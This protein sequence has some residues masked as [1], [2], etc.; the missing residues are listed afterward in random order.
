[1]M[2]MMII[3][4]IISVGLHGRSAISA[5]LRL[6]LKF[7]CKIIQQDIP[8]G[9]YKPDLPC[10]WQLLSC[11]AKTFGAECLLCNSLRAK[12]KLL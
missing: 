2:M 8:G 4:I 1:M 7:H 3:I 12:V 10:I 11:T 6:D 5:G 9:S